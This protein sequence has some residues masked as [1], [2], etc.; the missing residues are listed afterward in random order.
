MQALLSVLLLNV[1]PVHFSET[2]LKVI[3]ADSVPTAISTPSISS[4]VFLANFKE[5]PGSSLRMSGL[6]PFAI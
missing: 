3:G 6:I 4:V 5:V 1:I 2:A